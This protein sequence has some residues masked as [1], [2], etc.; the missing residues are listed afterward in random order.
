ME[1]AR[2]ATADWARAH[3]NQPH[4]QAP[5]PGS[6]GGLSGGKALDR[7][8]SILGGYP[9][10]RVTST[11]RSPSRNAAAGGARNSYH[12]N[13]ANPAV[14]IGG[15]TGTLDR[16]ASRLRG[17]GGWREG[18]LWRVR[19]HYDHVHVAKEGMV[20]NTVQSFDK[21]GW[22]QPGMT[23]AHNGTGVPERV[24]AMK[25]GGL[26]GDTFY[27]DPGGYEK[28][29]RRINDEEGAQFDY[30]NRRETRARRQQRLDEPFTNRV[31]EGKRPRPPE[32]IPVPANQSW[33][34]SI[35]VNLGGL[36]M[37]VRAEVGANVQGMQ[38]TMTQSLEKMF[39]QFTRQLQTEIRTRG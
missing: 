9:G 34:N 23:L 16:V 26:R 2:R 37:D 30:M 20:L 3:M 38:A 33:D 17:M 31:S 8:N 5:P 1:N 21:G 39:A 6:G 28:K 24:V 15:P 25:D 29:Q 19:G 12:M 7:V 4:H 32:L 10:A 35:K 22:L 36:K 27:G 18:P 13:R 14:D 11:Y